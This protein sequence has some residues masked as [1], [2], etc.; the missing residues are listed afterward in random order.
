MKL[1]KIK[2]RTIAFFKRYLTI[3]YLSAV[4]HLIIEIAFAKR[5]ELMSFF[6][7]KLSDNGSES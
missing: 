3:I 7:S 5:I 1:V 6:T 2:R 4:D